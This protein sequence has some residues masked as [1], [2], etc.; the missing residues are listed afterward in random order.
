MKTLHII[1]S[2]VLLFF[3]VKIHASGKAPHDHV[4]SSEDISVLE[5]TLSKVI[6]KQGDKI[7]IKAKIYN[8]GWAPASN[9]RVRFC[10][11]DKKKKR[12]PLGNHHIIKEIDV[13]SV[14]TLVNEWF[15]PQNGF[16]KI[17]VIIDPDNKLS[18][19]DTNEA[20]IEAPVVVK[21]LYF[22]FRSSLKSIRYGNIAVYASKKDIGY[23]I[24][25]GVIPTDWKAGYCNSS[26]SEE[27]FVDDW[28]SAVKDGFPAICIDEFSGLDP[29]K[30]DVVKKLNSALIK[31][32][33]KCPDLFI[34]ACNAGYLNEKSCGES[35]KIGA[36]LIMPE[37]YHSSFAQ[38]YAFDA[39]WKIAKKAGIADK[40]IFL[41]GT[42]YRCTTWQE[43]LRQIKY[44]KKL[45]PE[46][47]G[48]GF[49]K[50]YPLHLYEA[51][52]RYCYEYFIKPVVW[53]KDIS[54]SKATLTNVGGMDAEDVSIEFF[55]HE[56]ERGG[57][58]LGSKRIELLKVGE[59]KEVE[60]P[61][62]ARHLL[63][64]PSEYYTVLN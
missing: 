12:I 25:R 5:I 57:E 40:T 54:S 43:L 31:T 20:Y 38:D 30:D 13:D 22:E 29:E 55:S 28:S 51:A 49:Y 58:K 59:E 32:K 15:V 34:I 14:V 19:N 27:Q 53:I 7:N 21:D 50:N 48:L 6:P 63:I 46:M 10:Q 9:V 8:G 47:P 11:E 61:I 26:W 60:I 39:N 16:Y 3:P 4:C 33:Q 24:D 23:W 18:D 64:V 35:Y 36:D 56:P 2:F 41:L 45:A 17:I 62:K 1:F 44:I 37:R 52:D 42:G